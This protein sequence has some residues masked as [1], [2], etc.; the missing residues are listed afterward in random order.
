MTVLELGYRGDGGVVVDLDEIGAARLQ[1]VARHPDQMR[2]KLVGD[3]RTRARG[4]EHVAARDVDLVGKRHG[5]RVAGLRRFHRRVAVDDRLHDRGA[6]GRQHGDLVADAQAATGNGAGEAAKIGVRP[7]DPLHRQAE[8][9]AGAIVLDVDRFEILQQRRPLVPGR[10]GAG[11]RHVV[12][13]ARGDRNRRDLLEAERGGEVRK[14]GD[15]LLERR[16]VETDQVDL[17]DGKH[18]VADAEQAGD[19]G[20]APCLRQQALAR[21]HQ[22]HGELGVGGAGRHVAG[23]LLV[24]GRVGDD[25]GAARRREIAIGDVDGDALLALGLE[26]VEQ[27]REIDLLAGGAVLARVAF[28]RAQLIV[29]DEVLLVE[30]P[31]DQRR[32]AVVHGAAGQEAQRRPRVGL[33]RRGRLRRRV[34]EVVHQK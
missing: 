12:A 5:D 34:S 25:E 8:R 9:L 16:L 2:G 17:V 10:I 1:R 4:S 31:A 24:A 19:D 32:L 3:L 15:D 26:A 14:L 23:V 13:V 22:Q 29:E 7:V 18:R 28:E 20:V 21:I 30:Q 33:A 27:Q 6:P 11:A